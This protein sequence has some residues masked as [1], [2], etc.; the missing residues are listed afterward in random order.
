MK[1][2][3]ELTFYAKIGNPE[4]LQEAISEE[5]QCQHAY[6]INHGEGKGKTQLRVRST[7]KDGVVLYEETVKLPVFNPDVQTFGN[8]EFTTKIEEDYFN[9][10]IAGVRVGGINKIRYV[11]LS[12]DVILDTGN[13]EEIKLPEVKYE[14]DV[15]LDKDGNKSKWCKIDIEIDHILD[16]LK[17]QHKDVGKFDMTVKLSTL[18]FRPENTF[19][20]KTENEDELKAIAHFWEVFTI[21][22]KQ[23]E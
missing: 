23:N 9:A 2:E 19:S 5:I 17:E 1:Q 8:Q 22:P 3:T 14:V 10:W 21:P 11:F 7:T 12:K 4:G 6:F 16:L 13:G 15:F 20:A 18:P